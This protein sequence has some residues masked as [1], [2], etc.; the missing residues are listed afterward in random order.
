[1]IGRQDAKEADVSGGSLIKTLMLTL[2]VFAKEADY[3]TWSEDLE[4]TCYKRLVAKEAW[5]LNR[6]IARVLVTKLGIWT[7]PPNFPPG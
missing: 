1:M 3:E 2:R 5:L 4:N 7:F 6:F